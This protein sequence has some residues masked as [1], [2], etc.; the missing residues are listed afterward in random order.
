M[1]ATLDDACRQA[2]ARGRASESTD[3][4]MITVEPA[5]FAGKESD[6]LGIAI[7]DGRWRRDLHGGGGTVFCVEAGEHTVSVHVGRRFR[8][9][10]YA[11]RASISMPVL[12]QP[13]EHVDLVF[14]LAT[15]WKSPQRVKIPLPNVLMLASLLLAF[16]IG[17]H[18]FPVL[19]EAV[20]ATIRSLGIGRPW[21]SLFQFSVSSPLAAAEFIMLAWA[22][23]VQAWLWKHFQ[24]RCGSQR[25]P[26]IMGS[27][28]FLSR[29]ADFRKPS[30]V[31]K[32]QYVDPF[33]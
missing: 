5:G 4:S 6:F 2:L 32:T 11:G 20:A 33:E 13:G 29:R 16:R 22:I 30:P 21:S 1:T 24:R 17:W 19:R 25:R 27:P 12:V 3:L 10:G 28:Y 7:L 23:I 9:A 14:G 26:G 15:N 8:V 18:A 31:F